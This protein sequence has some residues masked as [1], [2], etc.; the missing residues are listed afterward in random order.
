MKRLL[1]EAQCLLR[2]KSELVFIRLYTTVQNKPDFLK[3]LRWTGG[4]ELFV[5]AGVKTL[6]AVLKNVLYVFICR[7]N[8]SVYGVL[9]IQS[10]AVYSATHVNFE[11]LV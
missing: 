3:K 6:K 2:S 11:T 1:H 8:E 10:K 5:S 9:L 7:L 4:S